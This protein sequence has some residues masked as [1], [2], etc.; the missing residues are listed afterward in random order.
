MLNL[1]EYQKRPARLADY[2]P[3]ACLVGP[4]V[5]L[6]K[7]GAL[8]RTCRYRGPDLD[9]ATPEELVAYTAR[10][11]NVLR[12]FGAGWALFFEAVRRPSGTYPISQFD[13]AASWLVDEERRATF[14]EA[15]RH[16]ESDFF[17]TLCWRPPEDRAGRVEQILIEDPAAVPRAYWNEGLQGFL[18]Q[19]FRTFDLLETLMP[20]VT[21]LDD[22]E[23]LTYLHTCISVKR[24]TVRVP[25]IPMYLDGVLA[26]SP[27]TGGL[28]PKLGGEALRVVT[29][30]GFPPM[31]EPGLLADLD[32]LGFSYRWTTRFLPLDKI[33]AEKTLTRYRRNWF[34]KRKSILTVLK[35]TLENEPSPLVNSDADNKAADA[36]AALQSLGAGHVGFGHLTLTI[37]LTDPDPDVADEHARLVERA[38]NAR[39]FTAVNE[40]VNAVDAWLGTHPG[41]AYANVRQPL[42]HTLNLAHMAPLTSLW[43]GPETNAHLSGPPLIMARSGTDTPF[44]LVT[45]QGDVGHT[46]IVGP[47]GAGKSVLLSL[48]ALQFRRYPG[49]QVFMFDKGRSARAAT[50]AMNGEAYDLTLSG[51]LA[52]QPL[53]RIDEPAERAFAQSWLIGLLAQEGLAITPGIKQML[54][55]ALENLAQTPRVQR[56]LTGLSALVQSGDIRSALQPYT[57]EGAY[58][59]LLDAD[60]EGLSTGRVAAFEMEDIM[61]DA[62]LAAPV[63]AYLFHRL[64]ARFHGS[65]SLLILD[66]AWVFLDHPLFA[67]RLREWLKTLRK[68]NVS[69]LIATQSLS[70]IDGSEIAPALI[71]SCPTRIF[72]ANGRAEEPGQ[73]AIYERFGL[74]A[75]QTELIARATPKRDYYVQCPAGNR[76]F[77]LEMGEVALAFCAAGSKAD[78]ADIERIAAAVGPGEFAGAWLAHKGLGWAADLILETD[79]GGL[80]CAAE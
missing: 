7:D 32:G 47:T 9:S 55:S 72:L 39:G 15:G 25:E 60:Q 49:A 64:E 58:G 6:N 69:V 70:D 33:Q 23:T 76:L 46:L 66:E 79:N 20:D 10:M 52:F 31:S 59:A 41:N 4:G 65:P 53:A 54:W 16:F 35:E 44:R 14:E 38:I 57:L 29:V 2:L 37:S 80:P 13:D 42:L 30:Q 3:W 19:A 27:L 45:H 36:D 8:Q 5:V 51:E 74:N 73:A 21:W 63:L 71:E 12:R 75:R 50:L 11:N 78:L 40:T 24:H 18:G 17:L 61:H 26:D 56:T 67:G 77:D 68:K 1:A 34:A 48:I 62:R 28:A 43:A 22:D